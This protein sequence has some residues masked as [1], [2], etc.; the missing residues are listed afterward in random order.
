MKITARKNLPDLTYSL[1][2]M[3]ITDIEFSGSTLKMEFPCGIVE[4]GSPCRQTEGKAFVKF[5]GVDPDFS[6][7]YILDFCGNTGSFTGEKLSLK[8]FI[9][10]FSDKS[11][12]VIEETYGY[13]RSKFSGFLSID[14]DIRECV[15]EI[16]HLGNMEYIIEE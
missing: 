10:D 8:D 14:T 9:S 3:H 6:Y 13:N 7:V 16:Y 1:H 2:D 5:K 11:F 4:I 12:E 15:I